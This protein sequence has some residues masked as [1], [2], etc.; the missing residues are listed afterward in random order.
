[1]TGPLVREHCRVFC[2][3][4]RRDVLPM[5]A[6][7]RTC[8]GTDKWVARLA[9]SPPKTRRKKTQEKSEWQKLVKCPKY[10]TLRRRTMLSD[11]ERQMGKGPEKETKKK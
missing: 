4:R 8:A 1:M 10:K 6:I 5:S 3:D 2:V 11:P 9:S 7:P